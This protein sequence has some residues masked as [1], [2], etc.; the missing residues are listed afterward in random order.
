MKSDARRL[1][2][3]LG[4]AASPF[5][6]AATPGGLYTD[7]GGHELATQLFDGHTGID[8][9]PATDNVSVG[10]QV[11][12][13]ALNDRVRGRRTGAEE[14]VIFCEC[15]RASCRDAIRDGLLVTAE[16]YDAARQVRTQFLIKHSHAV[17]TDRIV[18]RRDGFLIVEKFGVDGLEAIQLERAKHQLPVGSA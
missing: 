3:T 2:S 7:Y 15:G 9:P 8:G 13:R 14:F 1:R 18:E 11:L 4:F 5:R 16:L 10:R 12:R 6:Q 17:A